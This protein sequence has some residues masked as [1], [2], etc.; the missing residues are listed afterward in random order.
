MQIRIVKINIFLALLRIIESRDAAIV[1]F[2][3]AFNFAKIMLNEII[4]MQRAYRQN[5]EIGMCVGIDMY[6]HL[7]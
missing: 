4:P 2:F 6:S 5:D 3:P 1:S 7:Y